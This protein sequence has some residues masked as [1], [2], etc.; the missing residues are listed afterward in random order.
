MLNTGGSK[1][2]FTYPHGNLLAHIHAHLALEQLARAV[3]LVKVLETF[4]G[5]KDDQGHVSFLSI[6]GLV[7]YASSTPA[8]N[9]GLKVS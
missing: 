4:P 5:R 6:W 2:C 8:P 3:R 1:N 7:I 9:G